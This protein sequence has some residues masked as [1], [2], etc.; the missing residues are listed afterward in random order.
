MTI[1]NYTLSDQKHLTNMMVPYMAELKCDVPEEIIRTKLE[2]FIR[3]QWETGIIQILLVYDQQTPIGFSVYQI[4][5]P[6]SDWCKRPGW[7]FIREFYVM[8]AFRKRGTGRELAACTEA[9]LRAMG[10]KNLYLTS[11]QAVPFWQCCGWQL[12][13][14]L[15]SNDQYILEK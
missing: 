7:G 1:R 15:C 8:P 13:Q 12:T 14:E 4:D 6:A 11:D 3:Q 10:A 5:S 9:A 2:A